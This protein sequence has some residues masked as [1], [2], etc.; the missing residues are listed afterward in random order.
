[1]KTKTMG[2]GGSR[3]C[4]QV[5]SADSCRMKGIE[6]VGTVELVFVGRLLLVLVWRTVRDV[7]TGKGKLDMW[8]VRADT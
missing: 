6:G 3:G 5:T 1:M 8:V 4:V 2:K 7:L